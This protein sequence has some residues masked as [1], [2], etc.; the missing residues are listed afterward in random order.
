[1]NKAFGGRTVSK[2][3]SLDSTTDTATGSLVNANALKGS[4]VLNA[5]ILVRETFLGATARNNVTVC[6]RRLVLPLTGNVYVMS[7]NRVN[8]AS[9]SHVLLV[10][11][12]LVAKTT[13][14]VG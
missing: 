10:N 8:D 11:L 3:A 1:M 12:A 5:T 7:S 6:I 2:S 9:C 13:A 4:S 14:L